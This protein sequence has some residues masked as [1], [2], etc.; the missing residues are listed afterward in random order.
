MFVTKTD[1]GKKNHQYL[2]RL[3]RRAF[4]IRKMQ[5]AGYPA[6]LW[7][8]TPVEYETILKIESAIEEEEITL[9]SKTS[10]LLLAYFK[11]IAGR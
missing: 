2:T 1:G 6:D 3:V 7:R 4:Y 5:K 11:A 9:K 10:D 8:I